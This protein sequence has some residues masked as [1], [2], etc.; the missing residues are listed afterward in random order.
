MNKRSFIL[1]LIVGVVLLASFYPI[2]TEA[3]DY[4]GKFPPTPAWQEIE[5]ANDAI[6]TSNPQIIITADSYSDKIFIVSDG[7]ININITEY[8]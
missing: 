7:S 1:G 6:P 4:F 5:I 2:V 3:Q 8:P